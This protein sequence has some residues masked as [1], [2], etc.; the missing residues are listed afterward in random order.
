MV[1]HPHPPLSRLWTYL[2]T[3]LPPPPGYLR[4]GPLRAGAFRSGGRSTALTARLGVLL[5]AAFA[6]CFVTGLL[7]HLIQHPPGWFWW[8]SRPARLYQVTQGLHVATGLACVPLLGA[9]LWA[10][11]PLLFTW[12]PARS[13]THAAER[14][15]IGALVAAAL[16]QL[17]SGVLNVSRWY[18]PMP[19]L[20][21]AAHYWIGWLAIGALLLHL[22]VKLPI[23]RAA[24]RRAPD[25]RPAEGAGPLGAVPAGPARTDAA[26]S[27]PSATDPA[28]AGP[29]SVRAAPSG[30]SSEPPEPPAEPLAASAYRREL[31]VGAGAAAGLIT[32]FTVGQTVR[33]LAGLAVLTPRRPGTGP[34]GL[35]VNRTAA[36]AGV[37]AS[38]ADPGYRL[39]LD[40]PVGVRHLDLAALTALTPHTVRLPIAC[41][42]GWSVTAEWTGVRLADLVALA[43]ADPRRSR[44]VVESLEEHGGYR[45]STVTSPHT[46]DPDTLLALRL[47]GQIL[48][49]DHGYPVRLIAPN[50]PG[51]LQT[52]WVGRLTVREES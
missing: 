27:G 45:A 19:F 11:Y 51:V 43:G 3:P 31:L 47:N 8:P 15:G 4:R 28:T 36:D 21:T 17:V 26:P 37:L 24:L 48:D 39:V 9:K 20:F 7:S 34:Q 6:V 38:I 44:V 29:P 32:L 49:P 30:P 18:A 16:F 22:A 2:T 12:P 33:P 23:T 50:R 42:E 35:P 52:K 41:V 25:R 14:A 1:R 40:G 46:H 13:V 5:G 10:V